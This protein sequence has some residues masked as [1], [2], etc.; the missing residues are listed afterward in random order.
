[1]KTLNV[2]GAG[3]VGRTLALL[4]RRE[5]T[6]ALGDVLDGTSEGARAA[7]AFISG[8]KAVAYIADMSPADV[9]MITTP[10]RAIAATAQELADAGVLRAGDIVF[11]CSG[12]LSS[13]ELAAVGQIGS[14]TASVHPLK[15]FADPLAA[16]DTFTKTHCMAEGD[17]AAL[18]LLHP[19]FERIGGRVSPIDAEFK[20]VYHAASV[21]VCNYLTSLLEAGLRGYEKAGIDRL[22]ASDMMQPLVRETLDN[23]FSLGTSAALTGPI[24]RGDDAVVAGHLRALD[25]WDARIS[26]VYRALGTIAIDLAR[27]RG[28]ADRESLQRME[29][30]FK[31]QP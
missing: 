8:G 15:S 27:E 23:V 26:A 14:H 13:A 17:A 10:D 1:M 18:A 31:P 29:A 22:T 5:R 30:L 4:W 28:E 7:V 2:I 11:H 20:T 3:R 21:M 12:S 9:W 6:F 24:V 16:A 25:T 19:A